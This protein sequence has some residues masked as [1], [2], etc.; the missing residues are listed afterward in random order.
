[1]R[2]LLIVQG[3]AII[4]TAQGQNSDL[5]GLCGKFESYVISYGGILF[6]PL[7]E[8]LNMPDSDLCNT[9]KEEFYLNV[10]KISKKHF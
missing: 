10:L 1:M 5:T 8:Y 6:E 2:L 3:F 4:L 7:N 9:Y